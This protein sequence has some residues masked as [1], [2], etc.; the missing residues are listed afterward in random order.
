MTADVTQVA[1]PNP[2]ERRGTTGAASQDF[3]DGAASGAEEIAY[4]A[5]ILDAFGIPLTVKALDDLARSVIQ[6]MGGNV[7]PLGPNVA[8]KSQ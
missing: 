6:D 5:R 2:F 3:R 1:N 7:F 4:R 8:R